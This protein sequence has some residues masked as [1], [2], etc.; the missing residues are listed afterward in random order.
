MRS[1]RRVG[2]LPHVLLGRRRDEG[3]AVGDVGHEDVGDQAGQP[4]DGARVVQGVVVQ[5]GHRIT[6]GAKVGGDRD[7]DVEDHRDVVG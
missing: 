3:H 6:R 5:A 1:K 2:Q 4:V 7:G